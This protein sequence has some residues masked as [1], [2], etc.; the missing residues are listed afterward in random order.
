M[1]LFFISSPLL[2]QTTFPIND[3]ADPR[4][5]YYAFTNANIIKDSKN[6]ISHGTL[7][8]RKGKIEQIGVNIPLPKEAVVIDCKGKYIYPSFIDLYTDYGAPSIQANNRS[9]SGSSQMLSNTK[10][11]FGWNQALKSE[12]SMGKNF[13][14]NDSK[15]KELRNIGFGTVL[16]HQMDGISRGTGSLVTLAKEKENLVVLREKAAAHYSF[17]KG[18]STQDYPN[19][20]MGSIA[21]MRQL[22]QDAKWYKN[23]SE[24]EGL[25]LTLQSFN[26]QLSLPQIFE[27]ADKWSALRAD[28]VGDEFGIQYIIKASGEEYQRIDEMKATQASFILPIAFPQ[29]MD[30]EDPTDARFVNLSELKHWELAPSNPASFEKANITFALST[31]GL[32]DLSQFLPNVRKAIQRGLSEQKALE[33]LTQTPA[34]LIGAND[35]VGTLETGKLANFFISNGPI[36]DEKSSIIEN[37]IQ[38]NGYS[39]HSDLNSNLAGKYKLSLG[40][41]NFTLQVSGSSGSYKASLIAKDTIQADLSQ[42]GQ[43]VN[44]SFSEKINNGK[45]TRLTGTQQADSWIGTGQE[46]SGNW[47]S[48]SALKENP[49]KSDSSKAIPKEKETLGDVVYPFVGFGQKNIAKSGTYLIKNT[50]VWTNEKQGILNETDVL[51]KGGKIAEIGKNLQDKTAK[52][53]DGKNKH[54]TAG[55]IDEH[56]HVA[57]TGGINECSQSVTAE[58]RVADVIEPDDID[59]YR[60]LSGGVTSSHI[61]HGSC[62]TIGGQTQLLKF[63]WGQNAEQMKFENWDPFIKFALGENVKRSYSNSNNRFPDTRM[64]VEQVLMDA[65]TRAR[66]Y[67]KQGPG[68]RID[69][70]LETLVEILNKKRFITCHSYVQSEINSIMKVAEKF[71]FTVNTFTH[72]LEGYKVADKMKIHGANASTFSDWWTYKLEVTD[73]IPQNAYLMQKNGLNVAINSDDAE[74]ARRLNQ[75]A[76]KSIK[77][78]GMDEQ[79]AL[80]MVTL[81]PAKMLHVSD[82]VG[83]IKEGKDADLVLWTDHPLS[84]YAKSEKTIVDGAIVFDRALDAELQKD[85]QAEKQRLVQK[86]IAAKKGGEKTRPASP[87]YKAMN[88][89]EEDHNHD[90][91]LWERISHRWADLAN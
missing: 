53:I 48:W 60:Q 90:K 64:G 36:F 80:K 66:D 4:Q 78:A 1:I 54:L 30:L 42:K 67:E 43:L 16:T 69:L 9:Y 11:A 18:S 31:N 50:T 8:I 55:I 61:L 74:M 88:T 13:T 10:G 24:G 7:I 91:S 49:A 76:A 44:L 27:V 77:Y 63:R 14:V 71:G 23:K 65:F 37:W 22:F 81:N 15:A 79:E 20:L 70:E 68:K 29:A 17:S 25:N 26:E 82:R 52:I 6:T 38:G 59:I 47:I 19:S 5:G 46:P 45:K 41:E 21:L 62:N 28:K 40:S 32:K 72:I 84:I 12:F 35:L 86:M 75:E 2:G 3:V 73:A 33:A 51:I 58:V 83:S 89:C 57:A 39:I 85:L 34:T 87:S 56:S